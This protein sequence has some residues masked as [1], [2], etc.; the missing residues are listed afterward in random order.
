MLI[1][2]L[3]TT[4]QVLIGLPCKKRDLALV[5]FL[6]IKEAVTDE[7]FAGDTFGLT[8]RNDG[9]LTSTMAVTPEKV[10]SGRNINTNYL[11]VSH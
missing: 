6:V 10:V 4:A 9:M 7:A 3:E 5:I 1:G 11:R 2:D 8:N